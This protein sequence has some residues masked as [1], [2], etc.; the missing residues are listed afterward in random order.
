MGK[1]FVNLGAIASK[2]EKDEHG[3]N[4]YYLKIDKDVDVKINGVSF[5]GK[6]INVQRP[7]DKFEKMLK[8][9]NIT[10]EQYDEKVA[11]FGE[12]GDLNYITLE[13]SAVL[14]S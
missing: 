3:R 11:R 6:Y 1:K 4:Q 14:E 10:Q 12:D 8:K 2:R 5:T 9:G 13:L 7:T